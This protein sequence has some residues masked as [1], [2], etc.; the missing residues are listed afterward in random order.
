MNRSRSTAKPPLSPN[1]HNHNVRIQR[2]TVLE[3]MGSP[4]TFAQSTHANEKK[5][6]FAVK[7]VNRTVIPKRKPV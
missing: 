1:W 6:V 4:Y 5:N 7:C 2:Q 3:F